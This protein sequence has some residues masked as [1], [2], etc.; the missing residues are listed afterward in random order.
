MHNARVKVYIL[1]LKTE[2]LAPAKAAEYSELKE[3]PV[4]YRR[5]VTIEYIKKAFSL[6]YGEHFMLCLRYLWECGIFARVFLDSLYMHGIV[7]HTRH[8]R[9]IILYSLWRKHFIVCT[10]IKELLTR[11]SQCCGYLFGV[12]PPYKL[13]LCG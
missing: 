4:F 8:E 7:K 10:L 9:N 1:P 11:F 6:V 12:L 13:A 5:I 3:S 2:Y